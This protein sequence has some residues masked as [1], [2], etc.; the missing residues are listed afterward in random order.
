MA[1]APTIPL[2]SRRALLLV[3]HRVGNAQMHQVLGPL[4]D[5]FWV[6]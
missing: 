5:Q 3:A 2:F 4:L 6:R 1:A